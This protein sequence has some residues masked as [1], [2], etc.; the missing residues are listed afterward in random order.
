PVRTGGVRHQPSGIRS[1]AEGA[2][3]P[4]GHSLRYHRDATPPHEIRVFLPNRFVPSYQ[5]LTR[6]EKITLGEMRASGVRGLLVYCQETA[7]P[8]MTG[9][10]ISKAALRVRRAASAVRM[11]GQTS[12]RAGETRSLE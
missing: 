12:A 4:S 7:D 8:M 6:P 1:M 10:R 5:T 11:S 3:A 2:T 9:Y